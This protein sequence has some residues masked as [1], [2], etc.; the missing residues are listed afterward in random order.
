MDVRIKLAFESISEADPLEPHCLSPQAS[1]GEAFHT[2]AANHGGALI[3][4]DGMLIG[5]FTERDAL[6]ALADRTPLDTPIGTLM[7]VSPIAA[8]PTTSIAATV[9]KMAVGG[10]RRLPILDA[11]DRPCGVVTVG[12]LVHYLAEHFARTVYTLPPQ[13]ATAGSC[14]REGP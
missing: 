4:H 11:N 1:L 10:Y 6:R 2:L 5:I 7:T 8:R 13:S 12:G 3:C 14:Q 9:R